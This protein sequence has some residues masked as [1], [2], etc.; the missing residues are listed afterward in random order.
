[1]AKESG[2]LAAATAGKTEHTREDG[3][4]EDNLR[5]AALL[6]LSNLYIK[7]GESLKHVKPAPLL[8]DET[9]SLTQHYREAFQRT[10]S[11]FRSNSELQGFAPV[12][13]E[14]TALYPTAGMVVVSPYVRH[15]DKPDAIS[16]LLNGLE[17]PDDVKVIT[18]KVP[19]PGHVWEDI[20]RSVKPVA[21]TVFWVNGRLRDP[22][23]VSVLS[24]MANVFFS[25]FGTTN[26]ERAE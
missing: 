25:Q 3:E 15:V 24:V 16:L 4:S 2:H 5:G 6:K 8:A 23:T 12:K 26:V 10:P 11:H 14:W 9:A 13:V 21:V 7:L 17:T 1:M 20:D 18:G 19:F 22:A